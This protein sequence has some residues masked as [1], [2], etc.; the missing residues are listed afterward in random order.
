M[1]ANEILREQL[2][3]MLSKARRSLRAA[4]RHMTDSES[5]VS[6]TG[7][8]AK[9]DVAADTAMVTAVERLLR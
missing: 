6:V 9:K 3:C 1:T 7:P 4:Q 5:D 2:V 8:D